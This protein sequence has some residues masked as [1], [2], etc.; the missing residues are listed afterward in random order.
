MQNA[1][2]WL[3]WNLKKGKPTT[4]EASEG[5]SA[6]IAQTDFAYNWLKTKIAADPHLSPKPT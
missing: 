5:I 1:G 2:L 6:S 3:V 4:D